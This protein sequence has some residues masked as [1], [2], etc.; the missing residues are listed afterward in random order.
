MIRI[1]SSLTLGLSIFIPVFW[2]VFF[3]CFT[4]FIF[5]VENDDLPF[6]NPSLF[7][8][9]FLFSFL[10]F[11]FFIYHGLT[12]L[13]RVEIDEDFI[14]ITN[15]FKTIKYPISM[16]DQIKEVSVFG[17]LRIKLILN[18]TTLF[19]KKIRFICNVDKYDLFKEYMNAA[20]RRANN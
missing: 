5:F 15:Y 20:M 10:V 7:R 1:S 9:V 18:S 3:G 2:F 4:L 8:L 14:Y 11:G 17:F 6:S 16:I 12:K 13:K 19:G